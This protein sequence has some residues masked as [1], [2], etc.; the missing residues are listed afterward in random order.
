MEDNP[1]KKEP[2]KKEAPKGEIGDK[3]EQIGKVGMEEQTIAEG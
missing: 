3:Q 2:K 1:Q